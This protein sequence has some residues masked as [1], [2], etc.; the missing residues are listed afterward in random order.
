MGTKAKT[1][2]DATFGEVC[3]AT[4]ILGGVIWPLAAFW[5]GWV[6]AM[7]WGWFVVPVFRLPALPWAAA[8]GCAVMLALALSG[9]VPRASEEPKGSVWVLLAR[10]AGRLLG[11]PA[12]ALCGGWVLQH[13]M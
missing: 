1:L 7:L 6:L 2:N 9:L 5:R 11:F 3:A 4:V 12:Y 13:W 8:S 10:S